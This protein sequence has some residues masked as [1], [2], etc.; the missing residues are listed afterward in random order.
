MLFH[1]NKEIVYNLLRFRSLDGRISNGG[2]RP[3][4]K[5]PCAIKNEI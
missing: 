3:E 2:L 1:F 4:K 5:V